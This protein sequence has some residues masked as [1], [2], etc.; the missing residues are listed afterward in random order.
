MN[1]CW[2]VA[3]TGTDRTTTTSPNAAKR[4]DVSIMTSSLEARVQAVA[5]L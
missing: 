5:A 4:F 1:T 2:A 3:M